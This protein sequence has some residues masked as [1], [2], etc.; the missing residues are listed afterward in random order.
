MSKSIRFTDGFKQ[1][2]VQWTRVFRVQTQRS[3]KRA[4]DQLFGICKQCPLSRQGCNAARSPPHVQSDA[5]PAKRKN[6]RSV[7]SREAVL[8]ECRIEGPLSFGQARLT[9]KSRRAF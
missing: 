6:P 7:L 8:C 2:A 1:D 5:A 4:L 9:L 3:E